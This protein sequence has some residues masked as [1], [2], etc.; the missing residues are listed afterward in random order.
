[1]GCF[2]AVRKKLLPFYQRICYTW[3]H[4]TWLCIVIQKLK[5]PSYARFGLSLSSPVMKIYPFATLCWV[6]KDKITWSNKF[7]QP[8]GQYISH[9]C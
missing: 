1:M 8:T 4:N 7:S 3:S 9:R 6:N 2:F 5:V